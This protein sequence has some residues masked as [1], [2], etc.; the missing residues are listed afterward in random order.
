[1]EQN[2]KLVSAEGTIYEVEESVACKSQFI[3]N[4]IE[5]VG[6]AQV[7]SLT[8]IKFEI[9]EKVIEYCRH[10]K[11]S[12]PKEIERPLRSAIIQDSVSAWDANFVDAELGV[13]IELISAAN[14][15]DISSL[16]T[17]GCAKIGSML[18]VNSAEEL[19]TILHI[20]NDFTPEEEAQAREEYE[21]LKQDN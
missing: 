10:Y 18:W 15:L 4:R 9:L 2:I 14:Y 21:W 12:S 17:L 19:R 3:K 7:I 11:D 20:E 13:I 6:T 5:E 1:M 16:T 8:D